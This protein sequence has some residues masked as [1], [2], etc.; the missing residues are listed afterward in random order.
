MLKKNYIKTRDTCKV[1]FELPRSE[2]PDDVEVETVH[3][4]GDFNQW[5]ETSHPMTLNSRGIYNVTLELE[6]G[7]EYEFRYL[8]NGSLW[9]NEWHADGYVLS[10]Y[11]KDNCVLRTLAGPEE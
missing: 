1:R 4:V 2:W 11:G 5:D 7:S 9:H 8:I 10:D 3:L 6:P